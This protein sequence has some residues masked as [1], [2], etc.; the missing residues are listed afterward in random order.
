[1]ADV[2]HVLDSQ[3]GGSTFGG[4]DNR[5]TMYSVVHARNANAARR[6]HTRLGGGAV[7]VNEWMGAFEVLGVGAVA[8]WTGSF[9]G[10]VWGCD[11]GS[12][13]SQVMLGVGAELVVSALLRRRRRQ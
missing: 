4:P 10:L 1:M 5:D 6:A 2:W 11:R 12:S 13:F 3:V 9:E 8:K 7:G